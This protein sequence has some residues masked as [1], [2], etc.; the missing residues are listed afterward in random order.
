MTIF[1]EMRWTTTLFITHL[2]FSSEFPPSLTTIHP[3]AHS[4]LAT[5]MKP[6]WVND[7]ETQSSHYILDLILLNHHSYTGI[8]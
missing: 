4:A 7:S 5:H 1:E 8:E 2:L 6:D 3:W